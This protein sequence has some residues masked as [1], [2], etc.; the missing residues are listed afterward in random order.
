MNQVLMFSPYAGI[1][2]HAKIEMDFSFRMRAQRKSVTFVRCDGKYKNFCITMAAFNLN[3]LSNSIEK[4]KICKICKSDRDFMGGFPSLDTVLIEDL[5]DHETIQQVDKLLRDVNRSDWHDLEVD[6]FPFGRYSAYE[7]LLTHKLPTS[8]IPEKLWPFFK[9]NLRSCLETYFGLLKFLASKN[10]SELVVYNFLYSCNRAAGAAAEKL[11]IPVKSL[12]ANGPMSDIYSRYLIYPPTSEYFSLNSSALWSIEETKSL[13]FKSI[14]GVHRHFKAIFEAK[15]VWVYSTKAG[16]I[17][18]QL[19]FQKLGIPEDN[20]IV[21]LTTSSQDELF[22]FNFVGLVKS[23]NNLDQNLFKDTLSWVQHT[24]ELFRELPTRTLVIRL[25]PREFANRRE[26]INSESGKKI[27]E[28]LNSVKLPLNVVINTPDQEISLYQ[29]APLTKLLINGTSSVGVEFAALGVPSI[30]AFPSDLRSYPSSLSIIPNSIEDYQALLK[31]D[32][33]KLI[34][35][36]LTLRCYRWVNFRYF[37]VTQGISS[38]SRSRS[39]LLFSGAYKK[40]T[41]LVPKSALIYRILLHRRTNHIRTLSF[42][43]PEHRPLASNRNGS[44]VL[45]GS[46]IRF[47]SFLLQKHLTR[48]IV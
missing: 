44:A 7:T 41:R 40:Y 30:C 18:K 39:R 22:A 48:N 37:S 4:E 9:T 8:D 1:L 31:C 38:L 10:F 23:T 45:E 26:G 15:N 28:Y 12:Q 24:I 36:D 21:L 43:Y 42:E 5:I 35:R 2:D 47:S 29:L 3:E 25:H 11:G 20:E 33:K 27:V 13:K 16:K 19:I 17:S 34:D 46:I 14:L 6:G 32:S